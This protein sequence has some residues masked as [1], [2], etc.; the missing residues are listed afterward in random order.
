MQYTQNCLRTISNSFIL[1]FAVARKYPRQN[2]I[3]YS[4]YVFMLPTN[5]R[6]WGGRRKNWPKTERC[7]YK[8]GR[9]VE[10]ILF[11]I[12]VLYGGKFVG[13]YFHY[14]FRT[15]TGC[16][17]HLI[18]REF[19]SNVNSLYDANGALHT[20]RNVYVINRW[21]LFSFSCMYRH[22]VFSC[23]IWIH[24]INW[25]QESRMNNI[26]WMFYCQPWEKERKR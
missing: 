7:M 16:T 24:W 22:T 11:L 20:I 23:L 18:I 14:I 15:H 5:G 19:P 13:C 25:T 3:I 10:S 4:T 1:K 8:Y 21:K 12:F 9:L 2:I 17:V 6:K 26:R